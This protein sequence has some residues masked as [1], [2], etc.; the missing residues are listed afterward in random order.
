[1]SL[2]ARLNS[3]KL[4][5]LST[6]QRE[7]YARQ[8]SLPQIGEAG[9]QK[10]AQAKVLV[11]GAG[12]LGCPALL[13]LAAAGVGTL[14]IADGDRVDESNLQRQILFTEAD[15]G[16]LKVEA[17]AE[18]LRAI[19]SAITVNTHPFFCTLQNAPEM[20]A[21]YDLVVDATDNF[22]AKYAVHDAAAAR[23]CPS[24]FAGLFQFEGQLSVF[25]QG[26]GPCYRCLH[27]E[28]PPADALPDC[29]Q[30][31]ILGAVAGMLGTLQAQQAITLITGAGEPLV[32]RLLQWD[33]LSGRVRETAL[34]KNPNCPVCG[35]AASASR[36][37]LERADAFC[38]SRP[39]EN[40]AAV[41]SGE[42]KIP[43]ITV[44]E[45]KRLMDAGEPLTLLD[46]REVKEWER[47]HIA[48][49]Q[50][51]PLGQLP[52]W[53]HTFDRTQP[54]Y[55]HC[56]T[57]GRSAKACAF[58]RQAGFDRVWNVE[59]GIRAWSQQIDPSVPLE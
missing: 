44:M 37:G 7:R 46:V 13:Y 51:V 34:T 16:R 36:A 22:P 33:G 15:V 58:L 19:N 20:L 1:M 42:P 40:S 23:G 56:K 49:A 30:A 59:G 53:L 21:D 3:K 41:S 12:G 57:G 5:A 8:I 17:A 27:P 18:R 54:V 10:L 50:L 35:E 6:A 26:R 52:E 28:P 29:T 45:L 4:P 38:Q 11:V 39:M 31:G 32:G 55:I 43:A 14:G 2:I 47:A 9:Q 24:I 48:G 25:W